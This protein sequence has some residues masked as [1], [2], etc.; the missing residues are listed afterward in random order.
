MR[1]KTLP[2]EMAKTVAYAALAPA[3]QI[4]VSGPTASALATHA[5]ARLACG[6]RP[7]RIIRGDNFVF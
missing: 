2:I 7:V 4:V 6:R 1:S 5:V 3:R